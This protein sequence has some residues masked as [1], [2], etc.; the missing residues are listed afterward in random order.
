MSRSEQACGHGVEKDGIC[1]DLVDRWGVTV[2][3]ARNEER[4]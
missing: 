3:V 1:L 4:A 2:L